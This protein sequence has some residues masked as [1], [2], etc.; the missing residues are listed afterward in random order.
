MAGHASAATADPIGQVLAMMADLEAKIVKEGEAEEDAYT[1]F[2]RWCED[3]TRDTRFSIKEAT[4]AK[5]KS[6]ATIAKMTADIDAAETSIAEL[7]ESVA[8]SEAEL[9]KATEQRAAETEEFAK[10]EAELELGV[11]ELEVAIKDISKTM[12]ASALLQEGTASQ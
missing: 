1:E 9:K 2:A 8:A 10:A 4:T 7:A 6:E 11:N 5:E 12:G 3:S